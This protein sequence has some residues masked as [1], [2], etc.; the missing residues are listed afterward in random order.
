MKRG[1]SLIELMILVAIV[2]IIASIAIPAY[3]IWSCERAGGT[4]CRPHVQPL[5]RFVC[6]QGFVFVERGSGSQH[7]YALVQLLDDQG[8]G[9][10]CPQPTV[11]IEP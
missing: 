5:Y 6:V 1:F 8:H 7:N 3:R 9:I 2:A 11:E 4:D 10:R